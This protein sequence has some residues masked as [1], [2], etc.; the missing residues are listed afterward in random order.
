LKDAV[1]D[2]VMNRNQGESGQEATEKLLSIAEK[3]RGQGGT[4]REAENLEWRNE[5]VEKRLEYALVKGIT[6]FINEDTEE[7]R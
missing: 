1:E 2:V 4:Q 6:A 5:P 3:Y 7:A